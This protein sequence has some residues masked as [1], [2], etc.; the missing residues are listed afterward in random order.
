MPSLAKLGRGFA[1]DDLSI[2]QK[3]MVLAT[4]VAG[5][6]LVF[7]CSAFVAFELYHLRDNALNEATVVSQMIER[8]SAAAVASGDGKIAA[9]ILATLRGEP[10]V[11]EARIFGHNERPLASYS[12]DRSARLPTM[13]GPDGEV[14]DSN[15][16]V[17]FR[18]IVLNGERI[19][20]VYQK[21]EL[22]DLRTRLTEYGIIGLGV[23]LISMCA[24]LLAS[25][26]L[27][28][29]ISEPVHHLAEMASQVSKNNNYAVRATKRGDDEI[30]DLV[31]QFNA[32]LSQIHLRDLELQASR[33][34]LEERVAE[35]TQQLQAE[36][37]E[38]ESAQK[39]LVEAK[40]SAEA[41][42]QAKSSFLANMSH[43]LRTPLN[44]IIGYSEMLEEDALAAGNK[45]AVMDLRKIKGAGRHLLT[46][47]N[48]VLDISKIEAG[49]MEVHKE[50]FQVSDLLDDTASTV[51]PMA[52][53]NGNQLLVSC[54]DP[55][56][57]IETDPV[58]FRQSLLNLLSNACKFTQNGTVRLDVKLSEVKDQKWLDWTVSDTGIGI[59]PDQME[60]LFKS[61]S[62][63]D[64]SSTRKHGGTG[65]GLAISQR[66]C[67]LMGGT[68][69]VE[70]K[71][72]QGSKFTMRL[73]AAE[74]AAA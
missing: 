58:K 64:S 12:R 10:H 6:A 29:L 40:E 41:S 25:S 26:A 3:L 4:L 62:Q 65:L 21:S 61:F 48:D 30:G 35:R 34:H 1:F 28:R 66:L 63:V 7:A 45:M 71:P 51:E 68:I 69:F 53:K 37:A 55:A 17:L 42:N 50:I 18:P 2:K 49:R 27:Q 74:K 46:L 8:S 19:G 23:V 43:E 60:K 57:R 67:E 52:R 73:P 59:A 54:E 47:I 70:S 22:D 13:P 56:A 14:F 15:S 16:L 33:N 9:D 72:G 11:I 38:R 44:A 39:A 20:T 24:A 36:I 32:M 31:D 5:V